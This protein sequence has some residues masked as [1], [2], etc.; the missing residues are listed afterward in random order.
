MNFHFRKP[1]PTTD[2]L[3]RMCFDV[4]EGEGHSARLK[5]A[6]ERLSRQGNLP[7]GGKAGPADRD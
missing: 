1:P 6:L 2:D 5:E 7:R 4:P 3:L